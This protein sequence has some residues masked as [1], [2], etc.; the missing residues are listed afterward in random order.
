MY[1]VP[2]QWCKVYIVYTVLVKSKIYMNF[3]NY[4]IPKKICE[5]YEDFSALKLH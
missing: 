4:T 3:L 1:V 5:R 2:V